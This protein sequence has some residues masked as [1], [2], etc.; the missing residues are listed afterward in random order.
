[1]KI[2]EVVALSNK[3]GFENAS[4]FKTEDLVF[5]PQFRTYC[6]EN[7]CGQ[8][9]CNYSCPP[10]CGTTDEMKKRVWRYTNGILLSEGCCVSDFE[11]NETISKTRM[12]LNS[13]TIDFLK[14]LR[15]NNVDAMMI[16]SSGCKL[17]EKCLLTV[18][19][20]CKYPDLRYS[21]M[22]A[23][24]INVKDISEKCEMKYDYDGKVL[25]FF[26]AILFNT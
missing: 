2:S 17:C 5:N 13:K 12:L 25:N 20:P 14:I 7:Y 22:S 8:F 1:M 6:A 24:C 3:A 11:D 9:E 19:K 10:I 4:Y 21:C 16:G 26:S 15:K 18:K 23:Y